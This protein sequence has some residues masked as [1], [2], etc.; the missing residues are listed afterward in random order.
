MLVGAAALAMNS[1]LDRFARRTLVSE[2]RCPPRRLLAC[3]GG[4]PPEEHKIAAGPAAETAARG[5]PREKGRREERGRPGMQ[6][7]QWQ[8]AGTGRDVYRNLQRR[9]SEFL[10]GGGVGAAV[11]MRGVKHG[12]WTAIRVLL[13]IVPSWA[14][15]RLLDGGATAARSAREAALRCA[16]AGRARG[17]R[18]GAA[19]SVRHNPEL[20]DADAFAR[21]PAA[22]SLVE[23]PGAV[24]ANGGM[25]AAGSKRAVLDAALCCWDP[26]LVG[27][28]KQRGGA[29]APHASPKAA[30]AVACE[31]SA[32]VAP[33]RRR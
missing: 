4:S 19:A 15:G 11:G 31:S 7:G 9:R 16:A 13:T 12:D 17:Q 5:G 6:R 28:L 21:R 3:V 27:A 23:W 26:G 29:M 25:A 1:R 10:R 30:V 2:D 33:R 8:G 18:G 22:R 14:A 20:D 32:S 24:P